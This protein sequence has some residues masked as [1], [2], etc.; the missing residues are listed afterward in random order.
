M[1]AAMTGGP[2]SYLYASEMEMGLSPKAK[3]KV[4]AK[5]PRFLGP[6]LSAEFEDEIAELKRTGGEEAVI[7]QEEHIASEAQRLFFS[8]EYHGAAFLYVR[9]LRAA[10]LANRDA[11]Q[12]ATLISNTGAALHFLGEFDE[13][14]EHY[15][16]AL[17]LFDKQ[18][19]S[20]G[21]LG[22]W[23]DD[24]ATTRRVEFVRER[25]M[26]AMQGER[27]TPGKYLDSS[28]RPREEGAR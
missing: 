16:R 9:A 1:T 8:R 2:E 6:P 28:A 17:T 24:N 26:L 21:R 15:E 23:F 18:K 13:A 7:R 25:I 14:I 19:D 4:P 3:C 27:P 5:D 11:G 22:K 20:L 10:Q 12:Q